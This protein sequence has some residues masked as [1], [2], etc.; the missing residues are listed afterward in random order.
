[1]TH[2]R[3]ALEYRPNKKESYADNSVRTYCLKASQW[4]SKAFRQTLDPQY[5]TSL[6]NEP[7]SDVDKR[8]K[9]TTSVIRQP[10]QALAIS[11]LCLSR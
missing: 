5:R 2:Q 10:C 11:S 7:K 6:A 4:E 1:M 8:G 9:T 3:T